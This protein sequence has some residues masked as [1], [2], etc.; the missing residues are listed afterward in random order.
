MTKLITG[1]EYLP[2]LPEELP[3][4]AFSVL[5]CETAADSLGLTRGTEVDFVA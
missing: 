1:A 4:E 3:E 5:L 2:P